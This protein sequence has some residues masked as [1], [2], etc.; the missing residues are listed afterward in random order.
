MVDWIESI[1]FVET[2]T[3]V[4]KVLENAVVYDLFNPARAHAP[5]KDRLSYY[6]GKKDGW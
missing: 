3:Y 5:E 2:R 4:Q 6:L 1:P